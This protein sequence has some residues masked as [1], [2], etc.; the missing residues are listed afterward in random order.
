MAHNKLLFTP[1][2]IAYLATSII[3]AVSFIAWGEANQ[4]QFSTLSLYAIFPLLGLI[5]FSILCSQYIVLAVARLC[6]VSTKYLTHY[7][8]ITGWLFLVAI[9]LH[10]SLLI[11][12]LW[13]DGFGL[14]PESYLQ[15]YIVPGLEWAAL[16]GT[17]SFL[18]FLTYEMRRWYKD[19]AWWKFIAYAS[20][21][22]A[23]AIFVHSLK[24]G[25]TL[26]TG[27]FRDIWISYGV[28]L[29]AALI[30]LR[31]YPHFRTRFAK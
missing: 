23:V 4:W 13:R 15:H 6:T 20:D 2:K 19:R 21:I 10:P 16:L 18:V 26:Q 7:F 9:F 22:A 12:Q 5:A 25:T 1:E 3:C 11:W 28:T 14:P 31:V 8:S 17:L 29:I 30:Y 27:W 24:L